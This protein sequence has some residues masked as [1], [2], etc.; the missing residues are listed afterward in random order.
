[1]KDDLDTFVTQVHQ[2]IQGEHSRVYRNLELI[3][4]IKKDISKFQK[5]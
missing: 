2:S 5:G 1:M 3:N 4:T